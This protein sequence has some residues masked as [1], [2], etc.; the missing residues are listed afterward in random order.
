MVWCLWFNSLVNNIGDVM[1]CSFNDNHDKNLFV[2][3]I[4]TL[5]MAYKLYFY[6]RGWRATNI[7]NH[8]KKH[9]FSLRVASTTLATIWL[10]RFVKRQRSLD[11]KCRS[12]WA[13]SFQTCHSYNKTH[14]RCV[15]ITAKD[16]G[17]CLFLLKS[18]GF[19]SC[20]YYWGLWV[21]PLALVSEGDFFSRLKA[22]L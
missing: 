5:G 8:N 2:K 22:F 3:N 14:K 6:A 16:Q 1:Q 13:S 7:S 18:F 19:P 12:L 15:K 10:T 20:V 17:M 9:M 4:D 11:N 21:L